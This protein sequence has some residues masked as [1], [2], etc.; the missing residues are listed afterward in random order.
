VSAPV[1][2]RPPLPLPAPSEY[3]ALF[4]SL[5][6]SDADKHDFDPLDK[7]WAHVGLGYPQAKQ[8]WCGHPESRH[9]TSEQ[10][11]LGAGCHDCAGWNGAHRFGYELPWTPE[12]GEP[13]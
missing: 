5:P 3:A 9:W 6:D 1:A 7:D 4:A 10:M 13:R 2:P 11:T 12:A 8:C